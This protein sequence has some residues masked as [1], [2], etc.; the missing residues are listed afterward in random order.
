MSSEFDAEAYVEQASQLCNL[1]IDPEHYPGVVENMNALARVAELV[2]S[3]SLAETIESAPVFDPLP[4]T[5][6]QLEK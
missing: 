2:M 3:F 4:P 1:T 6:A 5:A